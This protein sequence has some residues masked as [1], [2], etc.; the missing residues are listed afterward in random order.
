MEG[1]I[2][3]D[4][5]ED[6]KGFEGLYQI[7]RKGQVWSVKRQIF[8]KPCIMVSKRGK[9]NTETKYI[10]LSLR[11]DKKSITFSLHRLLAIQ[12]IPN[13]LE[14]PQIDHIDIDSLNNSLDNLR[15]VSP[16]TNNI[17]R[18]CKSKTG[19]NNIT[20][21]GVKNYYRVQI[22]L[23]GHNAYDKCFKTLDEAKTNRDNYFRENN[24]DQ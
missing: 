4:L 10:L 23:K 17:N 9:K 5:L 6:V 12:F 21:Y 3:L 24:L 7:N 15:W 13:P 1:V 20:F 19:E 2:D 11:K 22:K 18:T 8:L 16:R 14:L